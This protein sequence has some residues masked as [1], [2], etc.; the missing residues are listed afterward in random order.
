MLKNNIPY[1]NFVS[2]KC[3]TLAPLVSSVLYINGIIYLHI[4]I[5]IFA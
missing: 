1:T 4:M 5:H 2:S 3:S